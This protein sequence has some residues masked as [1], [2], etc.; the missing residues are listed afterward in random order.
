MLFDVEMDQTSVPSAA[1]FTADRDGVPVVLTNPVWGG[2]FNLV[3]DYNGTPPTT[4]GR[5]DLTTLDPNLKSV[6]GIVAPLPNGAAY[7]P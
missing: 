2:P 3:I 4:S 7:F 1:S 6:D 5:I